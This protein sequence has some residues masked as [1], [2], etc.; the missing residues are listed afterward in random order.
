M[1]RAR[2]MKIRTK[3]IIG[4]G[5]ILLLLVILNGVSLFSLRKISN[6]APD[7][8]AGPHLQEVTA[9]ALT[10]EFHRVDGAV[11]GML[12]SDGQELKVYEEQAKSAHAKAQTLIADLDRLGADTAGIKAALTQMESASQNMNR[13]VGQG[14][15]GASWRTL[16][17]EFTQAC[18][19][20]ISEAEKLSAQA[21]ALA[22]GQL[23]QALKM[24]NRIILIQDALFAI[25]VVAA[26][27]TAV[28]LSRGITHPIIRLEDQMLQISKGNFDVSLKNHSQD[29][30][31]MLSRQ[32]AQ[33]IAQIQSYIED[34]TETLGAVSSGDITVRVTKEYIGDYQPI[35]ASLNQIIDSL[36][37]MVSQIHLCTNEV[38]QGSHVLLENADLLSTRAENQAKSVED[39]RINLSKV[40]ELTRGDAENATHI[41]RIS[42]KATNAV[43]ESEAQM[44][45]MTESMDRIA[46]SS[47]EI[48]KV[49]KIIEDI[50]FQTNILALN[51]A[52]EAARA[53]AAGKGFAVVADEVRRL[54]AKSSEAAGEIT[55]II[56]HSKEV[57]DGGTQTAG[58][59]A[60]CL[61]EVGNQVNSMS[62]ALSNIDASTAE[63]AEA[64]AKM[65]E[66]VSQL[67][68]AVSFSLE[69]AEEN[70]ASSHGLATQSTALDDLI[71]KFRIAER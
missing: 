12:L 1:K 60:G 32:L 41:K 31:G 61:L 48:G 57:V 52:V 67:H 37:G 62:A 50:A 59:T 24:T 26:L 58:R 9:V 30:I 21:D 70:S 43:E 5:E 2:D 66:L 53:G 44:K 55:R 68:Q 22:Q 49:I 34:I 42:E 38:N 20:A 14:N 54:A 33:M 6:Q 51:A 35:K 39:L 29:E 71:S 10:G 4:F 56:V 18:Q 63:Q 7:L 13:L 46:H 65:E 17:G 8:Y 19:Q 3:M 25:I 40:A 47:A 45:Q 28:M 16:Q 15:Q 23:A 27:T 64:F 11:K 36:T 69:A